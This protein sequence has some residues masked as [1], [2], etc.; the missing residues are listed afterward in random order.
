MLSQEFVSLLVRIAVDEDGYEG[1]APMQAAYFLSET[2]PEYT[3][4]HESALLRLLT[5]ANGCAGHVALTLGRMQ[6]SSAR[7]IIE[8]ALQE[9]EF[10]GSWLYEKA[11]AHYGC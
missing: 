1:D 2:S 7:P 11:L 5:A 4:P 10:V 3:R 9:G 6:S 8:S